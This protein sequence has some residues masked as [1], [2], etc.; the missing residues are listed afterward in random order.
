[1]LA[2]SVAAVLRHLRTF[3]GGGLFLESSLFL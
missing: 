3:S 1:L 2:G